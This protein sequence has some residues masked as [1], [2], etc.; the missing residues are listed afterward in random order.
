MKINNQSGFS[1]L[2]I[3]VV[4]FVMGILSLGLASFM[5]QQLQSQRQAESK[6]SS[7]DVAATAL[8]AAAHQDLPQRRRQVR[9]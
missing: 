4:M 2:E 3:L 5:V 6:R 8:Q 9:E 7:S 1:L